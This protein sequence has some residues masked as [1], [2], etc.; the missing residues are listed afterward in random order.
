M[1][2]E[3]IEHESSSYQPRTKFNASSADL[4]IAFAV[5]FTTFGEQATKKFAGS[6]YIGFDLR[7]P[8]CNI[9]AMVGSIVYEMQTKNLKT[10]NIAGNGIY[11]LSRFGISQPEI[12][13]IVYEVIYGVQK[14]WPISKIYTGGQTG[15]DIAGAVTGIVCQIPVEVTFPK[16]CKQR[17]QHGKDINNTRESIL[18]QLYELSTLLVTQNVV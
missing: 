11:T 18:S 13:Q 5:D 10:L 9:E 16:G 14:I 3:L 17:S 1:T 8:A 7:S 12:N 4:T 15:V 6:K 2:L